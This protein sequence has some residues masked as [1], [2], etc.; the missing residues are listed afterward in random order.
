[1]LRQ[2]CTAISPGLLAYERLAHNKERQVLEKDL[3]WLLDRG[4]AKLGDTQRQI[5]EMLIKSLRNSGA[6]R[7]TGFLALIRNRIRD[8]FRH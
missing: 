7:C 3:R 5:R 6:E 8:L 1:M 2:G 4:P